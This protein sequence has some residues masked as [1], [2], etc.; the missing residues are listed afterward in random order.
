MEYLLTQLTIYIYVCVR[1][2]GYLRLAMNFG[3]QIR[4]HGDHGIPK[5][6]SRSS[7]TTVI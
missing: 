7:K 5:M 3:A 4:N 2:T 1:F 6:V